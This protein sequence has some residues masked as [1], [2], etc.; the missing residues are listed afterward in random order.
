M[1]V[2]WEKPSKSLTHLG[3]AQGGGDRRL[4]KKGRPS[5][6]QGSNN[7]KKATMLFQLGLGGGITNEQNE[8]TF[9]VKGSIRR[10]QKG[11]R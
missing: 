8:P 9:G 3:A 11:G 5:Y 4:W 7:R 1:R 2:T 6:S 10:K